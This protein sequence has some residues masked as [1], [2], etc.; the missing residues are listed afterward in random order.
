MATSVTTTAT[1][2]GLAQRHRDTDLAPS[3]PQS[4][5]SC[6]DS[7][8]NVGP[9]QSTIHTESTQSPPSLDLDVYGQSQVLAIQLDIPSYRQFSPSSAALMPDGARVSST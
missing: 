1:R 5:N 9:Q 3:V 7:V 8:S 4:F 2:T 6:L